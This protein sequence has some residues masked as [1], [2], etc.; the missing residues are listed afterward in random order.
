V[1]YPGN[2]DMAYG[3]CTAGTSSYPAV[4]PPPAAT[5]AAQGRAVTRWRDRSDPAGRQTAAISVPT[6]IADGTAAGSARPPPTT[7]SPGRSGAHGSCP[8]PTPG[9]RSWSKKARRSPS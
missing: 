3:A 5:I 6:L 1:P 7:A 8:A 4:P 2:Q 9:T